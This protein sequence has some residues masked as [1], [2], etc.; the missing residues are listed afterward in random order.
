MDLKN[1]LQAEVLPFLLE[2]AEGI[3]KKE[4]RLFVNKGKTL[5]RVCT[6][7]QLATG[8]NSFTLS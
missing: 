6:G 7:G 1:K 5:I 8:V 2:W 3:S 4:V